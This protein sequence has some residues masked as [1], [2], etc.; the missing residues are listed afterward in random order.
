MLTEAER[1]EA[2][3]RR[4]TPVLRPIN[5]EDREVKPYGGDIDLVDVPLDFQPPKRREEYDF[6]R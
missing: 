6:G 2:E 5:F 1:R 3:M 4:G